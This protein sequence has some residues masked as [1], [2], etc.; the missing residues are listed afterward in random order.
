MKTLSLVVVGFCALTSG[1]A[2]ITWKSSVSSGAFNEGAN[3]TG[4]AAPTSADTAKISQQGTLDLSATADGSFKIWK[5]AASG[6][7]LTVNFNPSPYQLVG[8]NAA[9]GDSL[10]VNGTSAYSCWYNQTGGVVSNLCGVVVGDSGPHGRVTVS[11]AGTRLLAYR[12]NVRLGNSYSGC[13]LEV[14]DGAV[15]RS[16]RETV[17][18]YGAAVTNTRI[19]VSGT[20]STYVDNP[21]STNAT[22]L[23]KSGHH[24]SVV[25]ENGA[26]WTNATGSYT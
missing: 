8:A 13:A 16:G 26:V 25:V 23:P 18:G 24:N 12:D 5:I 14:L 11:G 19:R 7:D 1:A 21:Y 9:W 20:G 17:I 10:F 4:D 2:D 6:G 15:F 22:Q 3:W